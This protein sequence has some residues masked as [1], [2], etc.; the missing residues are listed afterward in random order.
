MNE[1]TL[2][3]LTRL[4]ITSQ[5]L[6]VRE[7]QFAWQ[8]GE[9]TLMGIDF[10]RRAVALQKKYARPGLRVTNA[11]QT[12]GTLLDDD[13][14][15]FFAEEDFLVGISI[16]GPEP[17][18]NRYRSFPDGRGS[19][20]AVMK[21]LEVLQQHRVEFNTLTCVQSDNAEHP[22]EVYRFL[23]EIGSTFMQF[24]PVMEPLPGGGVSEAS[25]RGDQFGRFLLTIFEEWLKGDIG[26]I[27][28]QHFDVLLGILVQGVSAL[29]AHAPVCGRAL[30]VEHNGDVYA[31]D[32][33]VTPTHL[34]GNLKKDPL[35]RLVDCPQQKA[36][37]LAKSSTLPR[38]CRECPYLF[39]CYG[40]CPAHRI[41]KTPDGE[42]GLNANCSGY[43]LFYASALPT[44][45]K[46]AKALHA[47]RPARDWVWMV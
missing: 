26:R 14:A 22:L 11:F 46:M 41:A 13:W 24:I 40:G 29:C 4:Y 35:T 20:A 19:F 38:Y 44:L 27:F 30:V 7:V 37:G 32:H 3:R 8:G 28:V 42:E 39:L 1:A 23:K 47:G 45:E 33:F 17:L 21:G 15:R 5:P 36:F 10:F 9:P 43:R 16:D 6:G 31:C 34:R 2:E 25:L 12:N 18:H